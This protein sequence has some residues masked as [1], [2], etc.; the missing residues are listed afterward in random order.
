MYRQILESIENIGVWPA[1][2]LVIFFLF[3]IG[4]LVKV[5]LIDKKHIREMEQLPLEDGTVDDP[6]DE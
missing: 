2:S 5:F 3:F 6:C 1:I 4:I